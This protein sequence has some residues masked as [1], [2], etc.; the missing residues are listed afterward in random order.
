[1]DLARGDDVDAQIIL[2]RRADP[3]LYGPGRVHD[4][5]LDRLV[6]HGAMVDPRQ[7]EQRLQLPAQP[8]DL[9]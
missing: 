4:P 6:E 3:D 8:A 1:M 5:G 9:Q 7:I 2:G